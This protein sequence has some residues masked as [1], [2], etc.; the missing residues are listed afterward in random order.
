MHSMILFT[1]A[2]SSRAE[3]GSKDGN[4]W[5]SQTSLCYNGGCRAKFS[6]KSGEN[7]KKHKH[8]AKRNSSVWNKDI[9]RLAALPMSSFS[10]EHNDQATNKQKTRGSSG[11]K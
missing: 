2:A 7:N 1:T 9:K 4:G 5:S 11:D 3:F 6:G 10:K 8:L